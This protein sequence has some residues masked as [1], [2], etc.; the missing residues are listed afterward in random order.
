MQSNHA[1]PQNVTQYQFRLV[2]DMTLKQFLELA[3]GGLLAYITYSSNL[4]FIVKYPLALIALLF[5]FALA[6]FP[7]E[8]RPLDLWIINFIK[9]IYGPT[10]FVWGKT[11]IVPGIFT[12]EKF[13]SVGAVATTTKTI[14]APTIR[15]ASAPVSDLT[16]SESTQI[17]S[18]NSLFGD[19]PALTPAKAVENLDKPDVSVRKL[20]PKDEVDLPPIKPVQVSIASA[21]TASSQPLVASPSTINSVQVQKNTTAPITAQNI[22]LPA[23]PTVA[24]LIS[25]L[26]LGADNRLIENAI[27]QINDSQGIPQRAVKSNPLGQFG[28]ATPL[29][30]GKYQI[31]VESDNLTF[32]IISISCEGKVLQP[33]KIQSST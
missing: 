18:L 9:A 14:K 1:I 33:I 16:S 4:I 3:A 15:V 21:P 29:E 12:Y 19:Q 2:G 17:T 30:N 25:G 8:D 23:T 24:N 32:P 27:V 10:R 5:G 22:S 31:E 28:I 13:E 7:I 11:N 6:F 20:S 26:I